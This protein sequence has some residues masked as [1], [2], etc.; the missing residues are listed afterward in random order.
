VAAGEHEGKRM[1]SIDSTFADAARFRALQRMP[2][3]QAQAYFWNFS[4]RKARAKAIDAWIAANPE[5]REW[6][7][8]VSTPATPVKDSAA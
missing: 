4:S 1:S 6:S 5:L 8:P 7:F 3:V 2:P